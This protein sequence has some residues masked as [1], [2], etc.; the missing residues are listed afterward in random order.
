MAERKWNIGDPLFEAEKICPDYKVWPWNGHR[1][2]AYDLIRFLK[3]SLF[4]ELGTYWGTS[5]YSFCQGVKDDHLKTRCAAVDTWQGDEHTGPYEDTVY[6][7]VHKIKSEYF[8]ELDIDLI[9]SLFSDAVAGFD[10]GTIDLLHIDGFHTYEAVRED[11]ETWLPKLSENGVVLFH[12]IAES[13]GYGSAKYWKELSSL[14]DSF[15]FQH[16]WGLGILFPKGSYFYDLL[17][18]NNFEDKLKIYE[19]CSEMNLAKFQFEYAAQRNERQ[20]ALIKAQEKEIAG[21]RQQAEE[22]QDIIQYFQGNRIVKLLSR[23]GLLK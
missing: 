10:D 19:Y 13:T 15:L 18:E 17:L 16:S 4:V 3:P 22:S 5:F 9:R 23:V 14:H 2:F 1:L 6:E 11:Y 20:D 8:N 12:D 7:T 21:L